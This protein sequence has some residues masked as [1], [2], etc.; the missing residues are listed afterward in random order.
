MTKEELKRYAENVVR[1]TMDIG[2]PEMVVPTADL[3]ALIVENETLER[4]LCTCR[5]CGGEGSLHTGRWHSHHHMEPP[6]PEMEKCGECDGTG[7][8]GVIQDFYQVITERDQLKAEIEALTK[9]AEAAEHDLLRIYEGFGIGEL[10]RS[11]STA[12]QNL[13]TLKHFADLVRAVELEF[14]M[15]PGDISDD[16]E[17]EGAQNEDECLLNSWGSTREEYLAQFKAA[18][19]GRTQAAELNARR[20]EDLLR[21]VLPLI[22]A[23]PLGVLSGM[24]DQAKRLAWYDLIRPVREAIDARLAEGAAHE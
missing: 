15:V 22:T 7:L 18:L 10:A 17:D 5:E 16:P 13:R 12:L 14:F 6:E 8:L 9:R 1:G 23:E 21:Q 24:G 20:Y 19:D 4:F 2:P 11:P 3:L